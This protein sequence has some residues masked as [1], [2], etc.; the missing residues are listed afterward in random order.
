MT[1]DSATIHA[2][3]DGEIDLVTAR[4]IERAMADD[5]ELAARIAEQRGL[6]AMLSNH[7]DPVAEQPVPE[8]LIAAVRAAPVTLRPKPR[9]GRSWAVGS[10]AAALAFGLFVGQQIDA[11]GGP[12]AVGSGTLMASGTLNS[13][14]ETQLASAQPRQSETRIG[15]TFRATDG[16]VC[17]S[18]ETV[19]LSGIACRAEDGWQLRRTFPG[20]EQATYRQAGNSALL[21][22]ASEVMVGAP[23]DAATEQRW[24]QENWRPQTHA[25]R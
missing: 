22:A 4:R 6:R 3:V 9:F 8:Q 23:A 7:Y 18:F 20:R 11:P 21:A 19:A 2:F 16:A 14:L 1:F 25:G 17:R 24:R 15:L 5:P 12:V 10:I 13:A